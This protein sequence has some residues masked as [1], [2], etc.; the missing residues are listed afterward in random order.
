MAVV[1]EWDVEVLANGD[2]GEEEVLDHIHVDSYSEAYDIAE[3]SRKRG[4]SCKIVLVRNSNDAFST[5]EWAYITNG[6]LP[7]NFVNAWGNE[8]VRVPARFHAEV[9][10]G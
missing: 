1:Y 9:K 5:R 2:E 3:K 8:S 6:K 4:E 10:K 7:L